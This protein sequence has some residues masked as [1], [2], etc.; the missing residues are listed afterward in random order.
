MINN[1]KGLKDIYGRY[2]VLKK[3]KIII[4]DVDLE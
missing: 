4:K 3:I 2:F 1:L